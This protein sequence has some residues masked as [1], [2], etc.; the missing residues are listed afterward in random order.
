MGIEYPHPR[1]VKIYEIYTLLSLKPHKK[2]R[3]FVPNSNLQTLH[4][5]VNKGYANISPG[6]MEKPYRC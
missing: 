5:F 4:Q 6:W 3:L 2:S 1:R